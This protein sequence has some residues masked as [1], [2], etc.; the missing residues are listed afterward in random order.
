MPFTY[1]PPTRTQCDICDELHTKSIVDPIIDTYN[2][3]ASS[4]NNFPF[5]NW[6]NFVLGYSPEFPYYML[7]RENITDADMVVDPFMGSGT[8][9]IAC[10]LLGISSKGVDANNFMVDAARTKLHWNVDIQALKKLKNE[11]QRQ[12]EQEYQKYRWFD[13]K[14]EQYSL[15]LNDDN[16]AK[17]D[18]ITYIQGRRPDMLPDRYISDRPFAKVS[19]INDVIKTVVGHHPLKD[20]FDL[21]IASIIVPVSNIRYGPGFGVAKPRIDA[22]VFGAFSN[23]LQKM[24]ADLENVDDS[25]KK[26]LSEVALGDARLLSEYLE[27]NSVS[28]IITSPPYPGDHEYTKHTRLELILGGYAQNMEEFRTIKRRMLRASTTNIYS[29]DNDRELVQ[30]IHG[31]QE[32]TDLINERLQHDGATSG[33]EKLYTKLVWEYFGGMHKTLKECLKVLQPGGKIAL[34]VSDSHAFKMV[35]IQTASIL[36]EIGLKVGFGESEILLWQFKLSTSHKYSLR[37]NVLL[38]TKPLY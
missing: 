15:F 3:K 32:I 38:L 16:L 26:T 25:R 13:D 9:L 27:P 14:Y 36:Q 8:T 20:F 31:I 29:D 23:K 1:N 22:D 7:K 37:E 11:V 34:L 21:A 2:G 12:V 4:A 19:L 33:F 35:H 28:F 6:Y 10:K 30:D 5:H 18:Y 24:I 17:K